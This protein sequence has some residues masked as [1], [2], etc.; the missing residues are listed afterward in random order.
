MISELTVDNTLISNEFYYEED[1]Y[2]YI[3]KGEVFDEY[4]ITITS[5]SV[6]YINVSLVF[7]C[8]KE[9]EY[10]ASQSYTHNFSISSSQRVEGV[11]FFVDFEEIPQIQSWLFGTINGDQTYS[12]LS[13]ETEKDVNL[14]DIQF[15]DNSKNSWESVSYV[16]YD[17]DDLDAR[18]YGYFIDREVLDF[19]DF[20]CLPYDNAIYQLKYRFIIDEVLLSSNN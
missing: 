18:T 10:V 3:N 9:D 1:D 20:D 19:L 14:I 11:A 4:Q 12:Q 17:L 6:V 15:Y 2:L 16:V 8:W 5:D 13:F 7:D